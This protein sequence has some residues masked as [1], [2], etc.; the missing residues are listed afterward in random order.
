[1]WIRWTLTFVLRYKKQKLDYVISFAA[2]LSEQEKTPL[3]ACLKSV[4]ERIIS[5]Q[6]AE[7]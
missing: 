3:M 7:Q 5:E 4:S 2:S 6:S 1:M